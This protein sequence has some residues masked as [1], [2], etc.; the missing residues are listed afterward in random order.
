MSDCTDTET[1][2]VCYTDTATGERT[3]IFQVVTLNANGGPVNWYYTDAAD[4]T[5]AF[6]VT[7]GTVSAGSCPVAAPDVE[8]E[9]LCDIQA[10]GTVVQFVRRTVQSFDAGGAPIDPPLVNDFATDSITPYTVTGTV[11]QCDNCPDP[12]ITGLVTDLTTLG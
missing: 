10:N 1:R 4:P 12:V 9:L 11:G 6:D 5:T 2:L 8:R 7:A 3:T